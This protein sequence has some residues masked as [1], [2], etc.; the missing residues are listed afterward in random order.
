MPTKDAATPDH[1]SPGIRIHTMDID[2]PPGIGISPIADMDAD[3]TTVTVKLSAKISAEE[4]QNA[5][6]DAGF[7]IAAFAMFIA[8][9]CTVTAAVG[10][11][12]S[13]RT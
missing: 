4:S 3:Q 9:S 11:E 6:S 8:L 10:R 13:R 1:D 7:E 5:L 2:Q 12:D